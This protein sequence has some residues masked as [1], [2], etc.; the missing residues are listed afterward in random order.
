MGK[1]ELS[2]PAGGACK[3]IQLH[4]RVI[5]QYLMK[6]KTDDTPCRRNVASKCIPRETCIPHASSRMSFEALFFIKKY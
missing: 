6:V 3:L 4:Q 5:S 2:T 1:W